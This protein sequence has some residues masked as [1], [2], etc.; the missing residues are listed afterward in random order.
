MPQ[1]GPDRWRRTHHTLLESDRVQLSVQ[2][3][4]LGELCKREQAVAVGV[5]QR[6]DSIQHRV[7]DFPALAFAFCRFEGRAQLGG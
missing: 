6:D 7:A 1:A 5:A 4:Q 3:G 2:R